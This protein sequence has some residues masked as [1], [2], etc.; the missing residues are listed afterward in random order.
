M[1]NKKQTAS[2]Q[3]CTNFFATLCIH[4]RVNYLILYFY[5]SG[6]LMQIDLK[7]WEK[8]KCTYSEKGFA[9]KNS[10]IDTEFVSFSFDIFTRKKKTVSLNIKDRV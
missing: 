10:F 4:K 9:V 5:F 1:N 8:V 2:T 6:E 3:P 7:I